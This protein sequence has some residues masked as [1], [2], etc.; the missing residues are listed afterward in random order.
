MDSR[1]LRQVIMA[2]IIRVAVNVIMSMIVWALFEKLE[3][4]KLTFTC[5]FVNAHHASAGK[6]TQ[7]II[8]SVISVAPV[9]GEL[10]KNLIKTSATVSSIINPT[11]IP[12]AIANTLLMKWIVLVFIICVKKY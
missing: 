1:R 10:K 5:I 6:T 4:N 3:T 12:E 7:I 9:I 11:T 2:H 8:N